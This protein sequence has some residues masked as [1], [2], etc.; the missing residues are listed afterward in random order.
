MLSLHPQEMLLILLATAF[1]VQLLFFLGV[2]GSFA[3]AKISSPILELEE[4]GISVVIAA[5][6]ELENLKKLLPRLDAQDYPL[7]EVIIVDDRSDDDTYD[8]LLKEVKKYDA[9][10]LVRINETPFGVNPKKYAVSLGIKAASY[11]KI[12]LTDAD[13]WPR[14]PK[15]VRY[16]ANTYDENTDFVLGYCPQKKYSGFLNRLIRY[17]TFMTGVQYLS[18]HH[19]GMPYMGVGRNLSY[20]KDV[21]INNK[22]F[23]IFSRIT[24]GDDD[25]FVNRLARK[26]NTKVVISKA[27]QT[28]TE[29]KRSWKAYWRQK[30]RHI[31][32]SKYYKWQHQAV[33][34]LYNGSALTLLL[35]SPILLLWAENWWWGFAAMAVRWSIM[36][37]VLYAI[38]RK[39]SDPQP[40]WLV[41]ILDSVYQF[42]LLI[43]GLKGVSSAKIRWK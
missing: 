32:V 4:N 12:L 8:F 25:L 1:I 36:S 14:S 30:T 20:R 21:F 43:T 24:G 13:C 40:L 34:N 3:L 39:L 28:L 11:D 33:L 22:G 29:P 23:G 41:P 6:D 19:I 17:E 42:F 38:A 5:H 9:F 16:I 26:S 2:F 31:S 10:R 35:L 37:T 18:L 15:W 27:G 7:F